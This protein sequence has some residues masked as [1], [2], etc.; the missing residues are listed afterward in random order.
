MKRELRKG[1]GATGDLTARI[2]RAV[3]AALRALESTQNPDGSWPLLRVEQG[4]APEVAHGLFSTTVVLLSV[5]EQL[6][7]GARNHAVD[8]VLSARGESGY[9]R[10]DPQMAIPFDVDDT[11][12]AI[13]AI[14]RFRPTAVNSTDADLI[15]NFWR[16]PNGPFRTWDPAIDATEGFWASADTDDAV[17]NCNVLIALDEMSEPITDVMR[18]ATVELCNHKPESRYYDG[19]SPVLHAAA[20][21][22]LTVTDIP[23]LVTISPTVKWDPL[24]LAMWLRSRSTVDEAAVTH[25]LSLQ[26]RDGSWGYFPWCTGNFTPP[27]SWG[28]PAVTTA[29]VVDAL[30]TQSHIA[31]GGVAR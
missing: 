13:A 10:F 20:R 26:G 6:S 16:A 11:A 17:V 12:C 7:A 29:I 18:H 28:S 8:F 2:Q 19:P 9:W 1:R 31:H 14:A 15:R 5:G 24:Q 3:D 21:A 23:N 27:I 22:G 4:T 25:L 30:L